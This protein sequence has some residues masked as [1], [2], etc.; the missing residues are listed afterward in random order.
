M[1]R[2]TQNLVGSLDAGLELAQG[3]T[4]YVYLGSRIVRGWAIELVLLAALLPFAIGAVDLFARC[5]RRRIPLTPAARNLRSRLLFWGY[6]GVLLFAAAQ[7]GAFPEGEP[8]PLPPEAGVYTPSPVLLGVLGALLL[9]GWLVGR[10]RLVPRRPATLEET[11]AGHTVALLALGLVALVVVATNPF[12]LVYLLP[13][14]YAWLWLPQAH[15]ASPAARGALLA[16]GFGG[17]LILILSFATRFDL[18]GETPWFLLSLVAVGYVPWVAVLLGVVWLAVAAQLATLVSGRYAPYPDARARG[19]RNR[20]GGLLTR[21]L[22][23]PARRRAP[24][25]ELDALER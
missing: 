18:G 23:L 12:A 19:P 7:L 14:L 13:S 4:S 22:G 5:R 9:T 10:E 2:A 17:P 3:T 20:A 16:L 21:V 8:R 25:E 1:G 11:L 15:A 24:Q 6:A